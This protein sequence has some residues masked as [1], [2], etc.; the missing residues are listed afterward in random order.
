MR[1]FKGEMAWCTSPERIAA[2]KAAPVAY[3][4]ILHETEC[5]RSTLKD[6]LKSYWGKANV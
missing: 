3:L 2:F 5:P 1:D 4:G 6:Q